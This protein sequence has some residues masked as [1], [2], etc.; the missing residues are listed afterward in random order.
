MTH[1]VNERSLLGE[2]MV[3]SENDNRELY[4]CRRDGPSGAFDVPVSVTRQRHQSP[5]RLRDRQFGS[6]SSILDRLRRRA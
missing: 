6:L 5:R 1:G 4:D 2:H 3:G